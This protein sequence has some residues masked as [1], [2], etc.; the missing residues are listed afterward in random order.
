MRR[1]MNL[2]IHEEGGW[3]AHRP[4]KPQGVGGHRHPHEIPPSP[5]DDPD[6]QACQTQSG[7]RPHAPTRPRGT[8]THRVGEG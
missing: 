4:F 1:L 7:C 6:T 8:C 5:D 3:G 2:A